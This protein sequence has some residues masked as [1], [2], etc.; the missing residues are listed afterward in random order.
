MSAGYTPG[1]WHRVGTYHVH[2]AQRPIASA[3]QGVLPAER[4]RNANL[5]AAAPDLYEAL[6]Y[7]LHAI[8]PANQRRAA[9]EA[10][11]ALAKARGE[12]S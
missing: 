6:D 11:A 9:V 3:V 10:R 7:L 4:Q 1:P 12:Q 2:S 5:I 8:H